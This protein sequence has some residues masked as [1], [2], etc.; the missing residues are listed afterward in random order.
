[1]ERENPQKVGKWKGECNGQT[2]YFPSNLVQLISPNQVFD[3]SALKQQQRGSRIVIAPLQSTSQ[4]TIPTTNPATNPSTVKLKTKKK[5][6]VDSNY[7]LFI[8]I[9]IFP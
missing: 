6:C 9:F 4:P 8:F 3:N 7:S 2:G 1:L 5:K